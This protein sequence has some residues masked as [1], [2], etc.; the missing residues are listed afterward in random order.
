MT[1]FIKQPARRTQPARH[2][3]S[4]TGSGSLSNSASTP[5][6]AINAPVMVNPVAKDPAST[7]E[8]MKVGIATPPIRNPHETESA[9]ARLRALGG[10]IMA[11][12]ANAAGKNQ[13]ASKGWNRITWLSQRSAVSP[14]SNVANPVK[15][16]LTTMVCFAPSLSDAQPPRSPKIAPGNREKATIV[17]AQLGSICRSATRYRGSM[18]YTP[19]VELIPKPK[20]T[21]ISQK[22][23]VRASVPNALDTGD[24]PGKAPPRPN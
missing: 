3:A 22:V 1:Q 16:R 2:F 13:T 8:P 12:A 9:T 18:A 20:R 4:S 7:M 10:V 21:T 14:T 19:M 24:S 17:L 15:P 23:G 11:I 5:P 6:M